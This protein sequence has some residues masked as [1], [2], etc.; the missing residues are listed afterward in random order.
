MSSPLQRHVAAPMT[1]LGLLAVSALGVLLLSASVPVL[2]SQILLGVWIATAVLAGRV[3]RTI[4]PSL[5]TR[6]LVVGLPLAT[7]V[8]LRDMGFP[9][10]AEAVATLVAGLVPFGMASGRSH[11]TRLGRPRVRRLAPGLALTGSLLLTSTVPSGAWFAAVRGTPTQTQMN[12]GGVD[13]KASTHQ[14][15]A[16]QGVRILTADG[17]DA[18]AAFLAT[19]DP[20]APEA[21]DPATGAPLGTPNTYEWRLLKGAGDADGVLYS[22]IRDHLHNH[23]SHRGRQYIIGASAASNAE[24]AFD[25]AVRLWSAGD[26]GNAVYWLGAAL[27][28]V[29]DSCVPQHGWFGVGV[30]HNPY[31]RWVRDNQDALA[32]SDAGIY[33]SD[34]R[35]GG[36][37]GGEDWSS[38]QP[39]G[40]A[41]ECAHRAFAN[42]PAATHPY[43][44]NP[45]PNDLQW[46]TAP[47]IADV[48]RM[49][50]GFVTFFF[51]TV[52]AP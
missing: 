8:L 25:E 51:D 31:E 38:S 33:Q 21:T 37:H 43:P 15:F 44:A 2:P 32:V 47:H 7:V 11:P 19:P 12:T 17:H 3:T 24:K 29:Q 48:Q 23:W 46:A 10:G 26:R 41:D 50:A 49:S 9:I 34:F 28:L 13:L 5:A 45:N 16:A 42:L 30:Y 27:H 35:V 14:W 18:V 20:T 1:G 39:R 40:W 6:A 52:G 4:G 36:G 22:Q